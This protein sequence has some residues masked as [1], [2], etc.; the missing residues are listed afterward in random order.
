VQSVQQ[1]KPLPLKRPHASFLGDSVNCS[2]SS[3][4]LKNYRPDAVD[5][6]VIQWVESISRSESYRKRYCRSDSLLTRS[7]GDAISRGLTKS[8]PDMAYRYDPDK[9]A[10]PPTPNQ[11]VGTSDA[12]SSASGSGRSGKSLVENP[13]Y[14][15]M[16]LAANNIYLR[17]PCE[18]FPEDIA[19]LVDHIRK[20]R[21]SPGPAEYALV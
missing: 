3:P 4:A 6:F 9:L 10:A 12:A 5:T 17:H 16:N 2:S 13:Y 20:D 11:S 8:A 1:P 7:D 21:G 14:R 19:S 15:S 18:E